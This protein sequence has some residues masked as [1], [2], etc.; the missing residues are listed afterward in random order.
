MEKPDL[1]VSAWF[2]IIVPAAFVLL[3]STGWIVA[4]FAAQ[5]A[6]VLTFLILR[7]LGAALILGSFALFTGAQW[8]GSRA[9]WGH[10]V[11]SGILLHAF[12]LGGIWWAVSHGVPASISALLAALQPIMT[13]VLAPRLA[14]EQVRPAQ[15]LGIVL[16]FIGILIV[17]APSLASVSADQLNHV[18]LALSIN[19]LGM[20]SLTLGTFYQKK[21]LPSGDLRTVT[22]V[23]FLGSA[24]ATLPLA[25]LLEDMRVGWSLNTILSL[26]WSI[27]ALS[28]VSIALLLQLIRRGEVARA[29]QLIYLV[30]PAAAVQAFF[31]FGETLNLVQIAGMFVTCVGV[32]L[33]IRR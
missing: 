12:Y 5:D 23:Q 4:R 25:Y 17:L 7:Y 24:V 6:E 11:V 19:A 10:A 13:A 28:V 20:L 31:F 1:K 8:P 21:F 22:F 3:W 16:G 32:A 33:A 15:W 26:A 29:A 30:P 27:G 14:G 2:T 9:A 18:L